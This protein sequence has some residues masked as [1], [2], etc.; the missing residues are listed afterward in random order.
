[1]YPNSGVKEI[2]DTQR[3]KMIGNAVTTNVVQ[4]ISNK[5]QEWLDKESNG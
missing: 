3:Y 2:S 1:V 5:F 4:A